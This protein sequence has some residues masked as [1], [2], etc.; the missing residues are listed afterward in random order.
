M[1]IVSRRYILEVD[2]EYPDE[3]H[4]LYND[5]PLAQEK[6]EISR[7]ILSRYC[8]DIAD[9]YGIKVGGIKNQFPT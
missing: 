9:Q 1:K 2:L 4:E 8:S 5:S 3:L 7:D 6:H